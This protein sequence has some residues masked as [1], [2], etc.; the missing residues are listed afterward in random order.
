[1]CVRTLSSPFGDIII[2]K[3]RLIVGPRRK[4]PI[5]SFLLG[6]RLM[7]VLWREFDHRRV[8]ASFVVDLVEGVDYRWISLG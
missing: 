2:T 5:R 6:H 4:G 1:M 3:L 7:L 8:I